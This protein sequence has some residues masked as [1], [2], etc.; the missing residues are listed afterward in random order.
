MNTV[1][2]TTCIGL[3]LTME[4]SLF[5]ELLADYAVTMSCKERHEIMSNIKLQLFY[6][7]ISEIVSQDDLRLSQAACNGLYAKIPNKAYTQKRG[8]GTQYSQHM[9]IIASMM[10]CS[11]LEHISNLLLAK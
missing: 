1:P 7:S 10:S 9:I 5:K 11:I 2:T 6:S 8:L 4:S 3:T